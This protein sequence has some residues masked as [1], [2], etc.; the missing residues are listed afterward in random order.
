MHANEYKS[1][2]FI[3]IKQAMNMKIDYML[4]E[5]EKPLRVAVKKI[6]NM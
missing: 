2:Q 1:P 3:A 6:E 5:G 4:K